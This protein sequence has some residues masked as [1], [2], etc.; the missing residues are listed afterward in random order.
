MTTPM[1]VQLEAQLAS[2]PAGATK[3]DMEP[4]FEVMARWIQ[5][6]DGDRRATVLSD[7]VSWLKETHPWHSRAVMEIALKLSDQQLLQE[8]VRE[9]RRMGVHDLPGGKEYP[10][11][12]IFHLDLLSTVSRWQ[13]KPLPEV[14]AYLRE[15][16]AGA[17]GT[18]YS[19]RLL[20][21]RAWFTECL[22]ESSGRRTQCLRAGLAELRK[23]GDPRLLRSGLTLLH[24]Y[25][26]SNAEGVADLKA[27]LASD[28]F[29]EACPELVG[30]P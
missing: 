16:R 8:T 7:L 23:W 22:L 1:L 20:A 19:R 12:L 24:A 4:G 27:V 2:L 18:S 26:A 25:F 6:L 29:A 5:G 21:I 15:L 13:G 28:E 3:H 11:W 17:S 9:A 30:L 14:R 10:P